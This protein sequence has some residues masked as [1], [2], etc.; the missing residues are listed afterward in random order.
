MLFFINVD[1]LDL[2]MSCVCRSALSISC[3]CTMPF[4]LHSNKRTLPNDDLGQLIAFLRQFKSRSIIFPKSLIEKYIHFNLYRKSLYICEIHP[5]STS[6]H[7]TMEKAGRGRGRVVLSETVKTSF[8]PET[9]PPPPS[10]Y[11]LNR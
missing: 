3:H 8:W 6:S 1:C 10:P 5:T 7:F 9:P 4:V 11:T 2:H